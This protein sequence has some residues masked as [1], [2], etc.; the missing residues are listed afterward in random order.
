M[1]IY[2]HLLIA[3]Y[4]GCGNM[5]IIIERGGK[6]FSQTCIVL[7][8]ELKAEARMRGIS[9]SGL[10][11]KTLEAEFKKNGDDTNGIESESS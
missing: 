9:L 5:A 4:N 11:C 6:K 8:C 1:Y 2:M 3:T 10:L 7:P